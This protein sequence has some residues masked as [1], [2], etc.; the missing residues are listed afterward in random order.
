MAPEM[1]RQSRPTVPTPRKWDGG[2][3]TPGARDVAWDGG[4]TKARWVPI[5]TPRAGTMHLR[6]DGAI[7][8]FSDPFADDQRAAA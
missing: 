1:H 2:T 8:K 6:F 3:N 4:G 5:G 7:T